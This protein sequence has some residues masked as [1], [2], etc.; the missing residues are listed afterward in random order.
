MTAILVVDDEPVVRDVLTKSLAGMWY[1]VAAASDGV[2]ALERM[3]DEKFDL[4]LSDWIMPRMTGV[5]LCETLKGSESSRD[6]P[7]ILL[8]FVPN[9]DGSGVGQDQ[10]ELFRK[11]GA[12]DYLRKPLR[13]DD[14]RTRL[15]MALE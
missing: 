13:M 2:E 12:V 15:T 1:D 5:E 14:L 8:G 4:I 6:I 10:S 11:A 9:S 7:V 3:E